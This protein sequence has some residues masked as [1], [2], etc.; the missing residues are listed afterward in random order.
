[1]QQAGRGSHEYPQRRELG[2]AI[3]TNAHLANS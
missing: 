3:G 2:F 1:M